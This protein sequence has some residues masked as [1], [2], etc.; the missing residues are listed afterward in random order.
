MMQSFFKNIVTEI[1]PRISISFWWEVIQYN[2]LSVEIH[3]KHILHNW[4]A[5]GLFKILSGA[6]ELQ[7][8][9]N[10]RLEITNG[11]IF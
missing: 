2:T 3:I 8:I 10:S 9:D 7:S 6:T 4:L 1:Q 5:H 11:V